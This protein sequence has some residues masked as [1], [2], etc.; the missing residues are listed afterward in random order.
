MDP[1]PGFVTDLSK[2]GEMKEAASFD[3]ASFI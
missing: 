1:K 3:A 2:Q